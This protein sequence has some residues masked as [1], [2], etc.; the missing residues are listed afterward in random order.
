ML[1]LFPA[2]KLGLW[3]TLGPL[4]LCPVKPTLRYNPSSGIAG[5]KGSSIFIFLRKLYTVFHSGCTNL[6]SYQQY[7][8]IPFSPQPTSL[9]LVC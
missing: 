4:S 7:T 6:H 1:L 9:A 3:G 2:P 5:S 8:R